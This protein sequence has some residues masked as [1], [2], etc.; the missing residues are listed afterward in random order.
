MRVTLTGLF[1]DPQAA[2][3]A[4][5]ELR[6]RD[7]P[8]GSVRLLLPGGDGP[9]VEAL[10]VEERSPWLRITL[11]GLAVGVLCLYIALSWSETW[12]FGVI[13]L[14]AGIGFG[15]LLGLWFGGQRYPRS[16]RPRRVERLSGGHALLIVDVLD[17]PEAVRRLLERAGA[18]VTSDSE[19]TPQAV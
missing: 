11:W 18:S 13:G 5:E 1:P 19:P 2:L 17:R 10:L 9:P 16:V 15:L 12:I 3:D 14:S 8:L 4:A 7:E 6:E